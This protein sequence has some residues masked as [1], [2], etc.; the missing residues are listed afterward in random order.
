VIVANVAGIAVAL[1]TLGACS[2]LTDLS[3]LTTTAPADG[4]SPPALD[5]A[6]T[7]DAGDTDGARIDGGAGGYAAAVLADDPLA[8]LRLGESSGAIANDATGHGNT[9]ALGSGHMFGVTGA[10]DSDPDT[11]L[12][13]DGVRSG[14]VLG[15]KLDFPGSRAYSLEAWTRLDFV[16]HDYRHL[17]KKSGSATTGREAYGVFVQDGRLTYE[18]IVGGEQLVVQ[19][20]TAPLVGRWV[21]VV[22]TY[23]RTR[24]RLYV[25]G[26]Q[27]SSR[28]DARPANP[29]DADLVVGCNDAL[30]TYVLAGDLDEVAIYPTALPAD[31]VKLHFDTGKGTR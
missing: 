19:A 20:S 2:L 14:I 24:I 9:G 6:T 22:S 11:A 21:H 25:D 4:G 13:L 29:I 18:R 12:R 30:D 17:F 8:Y 31:R 5:G 16:D 23:D 26:V 10:I 15:K 1:C 28:A 7:T 3:S 27:V